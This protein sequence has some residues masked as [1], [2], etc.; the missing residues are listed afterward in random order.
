M[1]KGN[2]ES[3]GFILFLWAA[4][5]NKHHRFDLSCVSFFY[6]YTNHL[7]DRRHY[8]HDY[9]FSHIYIFYF[10]FFFVLSVKLIRFS[11]VVHVM[12]WP[13]ARRWPV[14]QWDLS[15]W[16]YGCI[17]LLYDALVTKGIQWSELSVFLPIVTTTT[18]IRITPGVVQETRLCRRHCAQGCQVDICQVK[19]FPL[20]NRKNKPHIIQTSPSQWLLLRDCVPRLQT[21]LLHTGWPVLFAAANVLKGK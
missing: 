1:R 3:T 11:R 21:P 17:S 20:S 18:T 10:V 2:K 19:P 5:L 13:T 16:F 4:P 7:H 8:L 14:H 6:W 15:M 12:L 9:Y